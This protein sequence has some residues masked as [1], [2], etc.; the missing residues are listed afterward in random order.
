MKEVIGL[1][2]GH[3]GDSL[4]DKLHKKNF[5]VAIVCGKTD[6]PGYGLADY[7]IQTDL[8]KKEE[9][10]R[11]F[12]R[13]N[14]EKVVIGTGHILAIEL[15]Q[16]LEAKGLTTNISYENSIFVK[17]K[18]KTKKFF[19]RYDILTPKFIYG[20]DINIINDIKLIGFPC[21]VKSSVDKIQPVK[22][23]NIKELYEQVN[24]ILRLKSNVLIEEFID[25]GDCTTAVVYNGKNIKLI[26]NIEYSKAKAYGLQGFNSAHVA[27]IDDY[28]NE[29]IKKIIFRFYEINPIIGTVRFDF[30]IDKE[31]IY[32]LEINSV[33]VTG[34]NGS[35]Y[36][37]FKKANID[38]ADIMI[39]NSIDIFNNK[40]EKLK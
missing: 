2:A 18:I 8:S 12:V 6:E 20:S 13:N 34:Y 17:D 24:I 1:V 32:L 11:F 21:V 22:V 7:K 25:G 3:S 29:E 39:E 30:I 38:I 14:V 15:S 27:N 9:I 26:Q 36:P 28:I 35:A 31:K 16:F 19:K 5:K 23:Y 37:F 40:K 4:T 10:Y 33:I